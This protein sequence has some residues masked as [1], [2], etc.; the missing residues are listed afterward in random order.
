MQ[1]SLLPGLTAQ[2]VLSASALTTGDSFR[3]SFTIDTRGCRFE[4]ELSE[5]DQLFSTYDPSLCHYACSI[6]IAEADLGC[7]PWDVAYPHREGKTRICGGELA[8]RFKER[9][10]TRSVNASSC[11]ECNEPKCNSYSYDYSV[12]QT[13]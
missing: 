13:C 1:R 4:T 2:I 5:S 10:E 9:L 3:S 7:V 12:S 8:R 11:Q 6:L